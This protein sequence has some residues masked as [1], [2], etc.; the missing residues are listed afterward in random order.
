MFKKPICTLNGIAVVKFAFVFCYN[1]F[2]DNLNLNPGEQILWQG[3]PEVWP[4]FV[5]HFLIWFIVIILAVI[6]MMIV[7]VYVMPE[8]KIAFWI[9]EIVVGCAVILFLLMSSLK[10]A[11]TDYVVTNQRILNTDTLESLGQQ[12]NPIAYSEI[13]GVKMV[14]GFGGTGSI[15]ISTATSWIDMGYKYGGRKEAPYKMQ[16]IKDA[17][18]VLDIITSVKK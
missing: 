9:F 14:N 12:K 7:T 3:H 11:K 13:T 4:Y 15:L 8:F 5:N 18:K 2:M 6:G 10:A 16:N 1:Y 17:Q